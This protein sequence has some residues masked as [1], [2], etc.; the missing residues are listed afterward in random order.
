MYQHNAGLS[1][2]QFGM[3]SMLFGCMSHISVAYTCSYLC[4]QQGQGGGG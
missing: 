3:C 1:V 4:L 2:K